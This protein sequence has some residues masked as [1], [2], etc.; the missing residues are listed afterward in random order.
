MPKLFHFLRPRH[1]LPLLLLLGS[2]TALH[3]QQIAVKTNGL[4]FAA[5][6][7]NVGC[8]F[9]VGERSSIDISAFGAV[10]I[11]GNKAQMIGLMPEYRYWF[12]G[13]PMTREFVGISALGTSYDITWGD[14]I[15]QGDAAGA[16]VTFGYALNL[17]K[18]LNV[19][20]HGG[21]GAVYFKQKQYYKTTILRTTP[22]EQRKPTP[23]ATNC[24]PSKSVSPFLI[25]SNKKNNTP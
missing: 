18:R 24:C 19:E 15:Y 8:E 17:S 12:N 14:N 4:M 9:V 2:F 20:F 1:A 10:N 6:M 22:T 13:R 23:P 5:M 7:P 16:G 3:A 21:F 11:Y 25:S